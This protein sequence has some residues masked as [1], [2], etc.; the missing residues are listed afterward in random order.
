[1]PSREICKPNTLPILLA[2]IL[3]NFVPIPKHIG[4]KTTC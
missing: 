3:P 4:T 2:K 1:M